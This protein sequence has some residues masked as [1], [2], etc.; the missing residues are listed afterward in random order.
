MPVM[1]IVAARVEGC[2][3]RAARK[4]A[5]ALAIEAD[6]VD[7]GGWQPIHHVFPVIPGSF[8]AEDALPRS[9]PKSVLWTDGNVVN[10]S[11][12]RR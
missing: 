2:G 6:G 9:D 3:N 1:T 5:A 10:R 4:Q 7:I 8:T 11:N 12:E